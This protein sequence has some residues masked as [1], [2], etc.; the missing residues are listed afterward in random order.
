MAVSDKTIQIIRIATTFS[1]VI[2]LLLD[3]VFW[4]EENRAGII[5]SEKRLARI[6]TPISIGVLV[7]LPSVGILTVENPGIR[8]DAHYENRHLALRNLHFVLLISRLKSSF[9]LPA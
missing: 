7:I 1:I 6:Q 8:V 3:H 5:T 9:I 4:S 2:I